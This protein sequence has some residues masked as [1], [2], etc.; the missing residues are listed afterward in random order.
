MLF[1]AATLWLF[2]LARRL[3]DAKVAWLAAMLFAGHR[4]F[5]RFSVSGLSTVFLIL[6]FLAA[7]SCMTEIERRDRAATAGAGFKLIPLAILTGALIGVG[8][9]TRYA[10]AWMI[11]PVFLYVLLS[12]SRGRV[13]LSIAVGVAFLAVMAPWVARNVKLSGLP[14]GTSGYAIAQ[15]T[16]QFPGDTLERS[17]DLRGGLKRLTTSDIVNKFFSNLEKMWTDDL[18]ALGGNWITAFFLAGLLIPFR[19]P[20]LARLRWFLIGSLVLL[21]VAQAL[22]RTHVSEDT[23]RLNSEN[24][25]VLLSPLIFIYGAALFHTLLEQVPLSPFDAYG[26]AVGTFIVIMSLPLA[27]AL[28]APRQP[29]GVSPYSPLHIQKTGRMMLTNETL[30]SDIPSGV[31]WY[32]RRS[33][34]W[35]SLDDENEFF[36]VNAFKP[37]QAL[38]LTQVTTD[39]RFLSQL[40]AEPKGWGHFILECA[41]HSEVPS[42]F[43]LRKA[44]VGLLPDQLFL[45]DH[46][47][48]KGPE[49][50]AVTIQKNGNFFFDISRLA[51]KTQDDSLN[52]V[53]MTKATSALASIKAVKVL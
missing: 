7:V 14:F 3:F 52:G 41:E 5:W 18:P 39:K 48:W 38:F 34:V 36:K 25:L 6:V 22:G 11:L 19:T 2:F 29:P 31:A 23:P 53:L 50:A 32:G 26:V 33:C 21:A 28:L 12:I 16:A 15:G 40:R 51:L 20:S 43:P 8:G 46:D 13:K 47:R 24:L 49:R 17:T 4:L 37:I 9:L 42:G 30:M 35:L 45:S 44:P 10:F 1:F 27:L